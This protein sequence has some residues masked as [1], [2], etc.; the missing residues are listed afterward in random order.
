[1]RV[2]RV[3]WRRNGQQFYPTEFN[4]KPNGCL[5][6]VFIALGV[7]TLFAGDLGCVKAPLVIGLIIG[8]IM[9]FADTTKEK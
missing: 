2:V 4:M 6:F 5:G 1:M 7:A 8:G 3:C 9:C